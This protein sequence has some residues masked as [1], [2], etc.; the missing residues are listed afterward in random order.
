MRIPSVSVIVPT[1]NRPRLLG[2]CLDSLTLEPYRPLQVVVVND[3]GQDVQ[4][5]IAPYRSHLDITL[6]QLPVNRGHAHARNQGI[7]AADGDLFALCDDDDLAVPGHVQRMVQYGRQDPHALWFS[8]AEIVTYKHANGRREPVSREAFAFDFDYDLLRRW[9]TIVST[10]VLYPRELHQDVGS[11]DED[12]RDYWDWDFF[13]RA[14]REIPFIRIPYASVLYMVSALGQNQSANGV[15]MSRSLQ[16][17]IQK[18]RLNNPP[19]SSFALMMSE[20]SLD[21]VRRPT[22]LVWNGI[23]PPA[24]TRAP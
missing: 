20:P 22:R 8:D 9:N 12:M 7:Q 4:G 17:L 19:V 18:H 23:L 24:L 1:F 16:R 21:S 10:G 6:I 3:G 15:Q 2:E 11:F 13:L 5:V 14:G